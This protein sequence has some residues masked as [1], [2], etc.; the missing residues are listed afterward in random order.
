MLNFS[1]KKQVNKEII[2]SIFRFC[3][4]LQRITATRLLLDSIQ[5]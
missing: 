2:W 4:Y 1:I 5:T 3:L